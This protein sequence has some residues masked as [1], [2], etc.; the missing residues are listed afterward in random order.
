[1]VEPFGR[2]GTAL[3]LLEDPELHDTH[4]VLAPGDAICMFT[5]GLVEARHDGELFEAHRVAE[6]LRGSLGCSPEEVA[7][8]LATA[9]RDFQGRDL[10][11]DLAI[12]VLRATPV[13]AAA[14]HPARVQQPPVVA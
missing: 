2:L 3:G 13:L 5:D 1:V 12:L 10:A 4:A 11:D 14:P 7:G 8:R 6:V 9:A